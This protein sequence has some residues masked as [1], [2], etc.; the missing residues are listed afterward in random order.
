MGV[1]LEKPFLMEMALFPLYP[2][3]LV[4]RA[5]QRCWTTYSELRRKRE[6]AK[7]LA[8]RDETKQR[9]LFIHTDLGHRDI[10]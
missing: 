2:H 9:A 5:A 6:M 10:K 8:L 1:K 3:R 7:T 4:F